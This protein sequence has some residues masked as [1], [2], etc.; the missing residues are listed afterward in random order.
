MSVY[1]AHSCGVFG[2]VLFVLGW[3]SGVQGMVHFEL[4]VRLPELLESSFKECLNLPC[5]WD[6]SQGP[7][8]KREETRVAEL[9]HLKCAWTSISGAYKQVRVDVESEELWLTL[10]V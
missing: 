7:G 10:C 8:R 5:A 4:F 1:C 9:R 2:G 6:V 3:S